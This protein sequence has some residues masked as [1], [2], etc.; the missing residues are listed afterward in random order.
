[1]HFGGSYSDEAI[2]LMKA[3]PQVYCDISAVSV[4]MPKTVWEPNLKKL[5]EA[6]LGDRIMFGSDYFGM[7]EEHLKAILAIDWLSE[8]QKADILYNNAARFLG[9]T[10]EQIK[11]HYTMVKK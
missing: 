7:V 3:Y 10:P 11:H 5:Y 2:V 8:S 9:L 6:G 4:F 1:M